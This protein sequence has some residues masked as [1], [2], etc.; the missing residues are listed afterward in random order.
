MH[1]PK[2]YK[3]KTTPASVK[4]AIVGYVLS[5]ATIR[6]IYRLI[7]VCRAEI[8]EVIIIKKLSVKP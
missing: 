6:E 4:A 3:A 8:E 2:I 1:H 5:G 7:G